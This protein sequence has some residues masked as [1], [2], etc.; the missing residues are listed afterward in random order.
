M[1][2]H[3]LRAAALLVGISALA[4]QAFAQEATTPPDPPKFPAQSQPVFVG[5]SD[6]VEFRALPQYHEPDW[7]TE[8][9]VKTGKLPSLAERLPKEPLVFKAGNMPDGIGVYGDVMRH[10]IGD[11]RKAGTTSPA[12]ARAGAASTSG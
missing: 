9:F 10:V 8:K 2:S 4:A 5:I 6:I 12:R 7:V 11:G 1:T 3:G